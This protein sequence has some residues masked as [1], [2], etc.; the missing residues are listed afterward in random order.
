MQGMERKQTYVSKMV[1]MAMYRIKSEVVS[2]ISGFNLMSICV[3][4]RV[5]AISQ[6]DLQLSGAFSFLHL[7]LKPEQLRHPERPG[8][9]RAYL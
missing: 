1:G 7:R 6:V 8:K 4:V 2:E 9:K 3:R 5:K